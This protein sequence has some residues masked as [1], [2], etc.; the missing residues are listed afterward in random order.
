MLEGFMGAGNNPG[1]DFGS[2]SQF[3]DYLQQTSPDMA[4]SMTAQYYNLPGMETFG[5]GGSDA[6]WTSFEMDNPAYGQTLINDG[7]GNFPSYYDPEYL[8]ESQQ[9]FLD[10]LMN[11]INPQQSAPQ[12]F[13]GGGGQAGQQ[14]RDL[15][16]PGTSGGF[17]GVGSG[18]GGGGGMQSM[19]K[20]LMG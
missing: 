18:I 19:L 9:G 11:Y 8:E 5:F 16:Y 10:N 14:A 12:Q 6:A 1:I 7:S 20:S 15:Y 3:F 17:A 13:T 4:Q 2:G